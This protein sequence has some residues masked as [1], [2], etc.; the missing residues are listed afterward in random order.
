M[1][2]CVKLYAITVVVF[3][4][5]DL[6][7]L[8]LVMPSFYKSQLGSLAR[9]QN[10]TLAPLW[11]AAILVYLLIPAGIIL[12]ALPKV[13]SGGTTFSAFA[14]GFLFGVVVYGIY[15]FTNLATLSGWPVKLSFADTAWGGVLCATVTA[16][17]FR[18]HRWLS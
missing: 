14:W 9:R 7:Y 12:F 11:W 10:D 6:T 18:L 5:V 4:V 17:A 16:V 15:D 2:Q 13:G 8:G 1:W 3:L